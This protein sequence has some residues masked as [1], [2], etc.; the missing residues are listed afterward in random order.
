VKASHS[1]AA[2]DSHHMKS[3]YRMLLLDRIRIKKKGRPATLKIH[4]STTRHQ[5][6]C[7]LSFTNAILDNHLQIKEELG[8]D[9]MVRACYS[10]TLPATPFQML[11]HSQRSSRQAARWFPV[12][13]TT[14]CNRGCP[15]ISSTA[16]VTQLLP[17]DCYC[18]KRRQVFQIN[19]TAS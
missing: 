17:R 9:G 18:P 10:P 13:T 6:S 5:G 14:L 16:G 15:G 12:S 3:M 7:G 8:N 4:F 1:S 11:L 19:E 2:T